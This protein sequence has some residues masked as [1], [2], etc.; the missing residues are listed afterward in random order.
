MLITPT[1]LQQQQQQ[2]AEPPAPTA[3]AAQVM[4]LLMSPKAPGDARLAAA[5]ALLVTLQGCSSRGSSGDGGSQGLEL[6]GL[7]PEA[8]VVML[9]STELPV[10]GVEDLMEVSGGGGEGE[11]VEGEGDVGE[12]DGGM[13]RVEGD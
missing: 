9:Q 7:L 6:L 12:G 5:V 13:W 2:A 1:T 8:A 11:G 4:A 10:V 3:T